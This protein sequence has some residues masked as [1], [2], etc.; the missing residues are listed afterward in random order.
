MSKFI[1]VRD[2]DMRSHFL[3]VDHIV[4]VTKVPGNTTLKTSPYAYIIVADGSSSG[5]K[6]IRLSSD[7]PDTADEVINKIKTA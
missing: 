3:N 6:E 1:W 2:A 4:R 7:T 5:N